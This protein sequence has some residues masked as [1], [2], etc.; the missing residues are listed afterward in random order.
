VQFLARGT[1]PPTVF[2]VLPIYM[3]L[4]EHRGIGSKKIV[5]LTRSEI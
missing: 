3:E 2:Q 4:G 5:H 1:R